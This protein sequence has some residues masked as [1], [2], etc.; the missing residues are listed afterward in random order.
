MPPIP[1]SSLNTPRVIPMEVM[2]CLLACLAL[3]SCSTPGPVD[4]FYSA[5]ATTQVPTDRPYGQ[6][7]RLALHSAEIEARHNLLEPL[8]E[9]DVD[10]RGRIEQHATADPFVRAMVMDLV[11]NGRISSRGI[12][13]NGQASVTVELSRETID[14]F[15]AD[16]TSP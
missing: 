14:Q 12:D 11:R 9:L 6:A 7:R 5:S 13:D 4:A 16:L 15:L 3:F 2:I 1:N 10:G 8:L